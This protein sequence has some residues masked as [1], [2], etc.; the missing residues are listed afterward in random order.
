MWGTRAKDIWTGVIYI[1]A[2]GSGIVGKRYLGCAIWAKDIWTG[3]L[4]LVCLDQEHL[5]RDI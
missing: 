1:G 5:K 2:F 4:N 3:T